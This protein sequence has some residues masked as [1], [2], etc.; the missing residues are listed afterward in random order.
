MD[1]TSPGPE[2]EGMDGLRNLIADKSKNLRQMQ[3]F[4]RAYIA[5]TSKKLSDESTTTQGLA[6]PL[7]EP[8]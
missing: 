6:T 2:D 8:D 5:T 1:A 7:S 4:A 3:K